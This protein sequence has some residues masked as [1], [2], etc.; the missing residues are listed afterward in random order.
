MFRKHCSTIG[1]KTSGC[2]CTWYVE[3]CPLLTLESFLFPVYLPHHCFYV[4]AGKGDCMLIAVILVSWTVMNY[5]ARTLCFQGK[6]HLFWGEPALFAPP[7]AH[8]LEYLVHDSSSDIEHLG[9]SC[10]EIFY[11]LYLVNGSASA[12]RPYGLVLAESQLVD[13]V[14]SR[15]SWISL[16]EFWASFS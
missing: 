6:V 9:R 10:S 1:G 8:A 4:Q 13:L 5:W 11:G 3:L 16:A 14:S 7:F 2:W 12:F 15:S